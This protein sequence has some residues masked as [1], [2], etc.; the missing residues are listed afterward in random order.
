MLTNF[1]KNKTIILINLLAIVISISGFIYFYTNGQV[2]LYYGDAVSRLNISRK[3]IDNLNPGIGQIGSVWLPLPLLLMVPFVWNN[4]LWHTGL[5]GYFISG[6]SFVVTAN[7][8]YKFG[9][10]AFRSKFSAVVMALISIA[11]LNLLYIQTTAMSESIFIASVVASNYFLYKW[12]KHKDTLNLLIAGMSIALC[13]FIRYEGYFVLLLSI[14]LVCVI[15]FLNNNDKKKVEG[16]LILFS[17][18]ALTGIFLWIAYNWAIFGNA[19]YWKD[20]YSNKANII[21]SELSNVSIASSKEQSPFELDMLFHSI[22]KYWNSVAQMN[23]IIITITA[24]F[25]FICFVAWLLHKKKFFKQPE[26]LTLFLPLGVFVFVVYA[27]Y[28]SFPLT[29]PSLTI[30][31]LL[32]KSTNDIGEYNIRYGLNMFPFVVILIGWGLSFS[33]WTKTILVLLLSLQ[34]I[35]TFW[36]PFFTLYSLPRNLVSD[37]S[38]K[39][40]GNNAAGEW[41]KTNYDGG[42]IMISAQNHNPT[43]FF[44]N[45][46]YKN[47]IHEGAGYYWIESRDDPQKYARWLFMYI[48]P[49]DL[50]KTDDLVARYATLNI[51]KVNLYFDEVFNDGRYIIYKKKN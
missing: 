49:D 9:I 17:T 4:T 34:F 41:L 18:L 6:I 45:I 50:N 14:L 1:F 37:Q 7:L 48:P 21:S 2:N 27:V 44:L 3:I 35:T 39:H 22:Y 23:G 16:D 43:M 20:I 15:S 11:S 46:D 12:A 25:L 36:T 32:S 24:T 13:S 26:L 38:S 28:G 19:F 51:D 42:L 29:L 5:A 47:Y 33:K 30:E 40:T 8:L 10:E 31:H